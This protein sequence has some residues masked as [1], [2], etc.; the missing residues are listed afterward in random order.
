MT[1]E[2]RTPKWAGLT[3]AEREDVKKAIQQAE[4][5]TSGE[6]VPML[7]RRSSTVGHVPM[8]VMSLLAIV[9][10]TI[11]SFYPLAWWAWGITVLAILALTRL[12]ST[13]DTTQRLLTADADEI[14]QVHQRAEL[15][16][17]ENKVGHTRGNTGVLL[18]VS[19]MEHRAVVLADEAISS[20]LP[21]E[22]WEGVLTLLLNGIKQGSAADGFKDAIRECGRLL[23][24]HFPRQSQPMNEIDNTFLIKE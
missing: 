9:A 6:I 24:T 15:E 21:P 10:L 12:L 8:L 13:L 17:F 18:F 20:K 11:D 19:Q 14:S 22:T 23:S 1:P 5:Q 2:T 3:D 4:S 16:F 7:V